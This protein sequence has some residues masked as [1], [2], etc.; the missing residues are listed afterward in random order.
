LIAQ[1]LERDPDWTKLPSTTPAPVRRLLERCLKKD[2][3][4]RLH[5]I[6]DARFTIEDALASPVFPLD[7]AQGRKDP[8]LHVTADPG[9]HPDQAG[10]HAAAVTRALQPT[11]AVWRHPLPVGLAIATLALA[12]ALLWTLNRTP[13]ADATEPTHVSLTLPVTQELTVWGHT[14]SPD[15][16]HIV[17]SAVTDE[18]P[19]GPEGN[20]SRLFHRNLADGASRPLPGTEGAGVPF[21]SPDGEWVAFASLSDL[22][23]KR[24]ALGGGG[25]T[26]VADLSGSNLEYPGAWTS[27]DHILFGDRVGPLRRVPSAGGPSEVVVPRTALEAGEQGMTWP[28]PLP[29]GSGTMFNPRY[30]F[31]VVA[32]YVDGGRRTLL[33]DAFQAQFSPTGHLL[34]WRAADSKQVDVWAVG[35]DATRAELTGTPVSVLSVPGTSQLFCQVS[36]SGTLVYRA[37]DPE[38]H[39]G[40]FKWEALDGRPTPPQLT[41]P[42]PNVSRISGPRISPDGR[43]V[44]Y[45]E[46]AGPDDLRLIVADLT[47]G[48]R[49]ILAAGQNF[50]AI[51][52]PDSR[53]VV[54]QVP[55]GE[56]GGAGI[57]WKPADGSTAPERL[58]SSKVWQQPQ[59]VTRDGRFLIYQEGGA[60]GT[61]D[62]A[63][64][65]NYDLWLLPLSPRGEPRPLLQSKANE[66]L[67]SL[68]PDGRWLAYV[69]DETGRE[70]IWVR[71]FPPEGSAA[72]QV[73]Q[74]GGTEPVWA[75]NGAT[76]YY[77]D[78]AGM[79]LYAVP[80]THGSVPQFGAPTVRNGRWLGLMPFGRL[81]DITPD[82][83][84]LLFL[85]EPTHSRELRVVFNFDQVIR[86][87]MA[88]ALK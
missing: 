20:V 29:G 30:D 64:A 63:G 15:G 37:G 87:K 13:A 34:F 32:V 11:R 55:P 53:R 9:R 62:A 65:D 14:V 59:F 6:A 3:R 74:S 1:I 8:G 82:G 51:W 71:V 86:R 33:R 50:W 42:P 66:K 70:E 81:Y 56:P 60:I 61:R 43:F 57:L 52:M 7:S 69:S 38:Y 67:P 75:P 26:A 39:G 83:S 19:P 45:H 35:F 44:L 17:Y 18:G 76:L 41:D 21:F 49:R 79:R 27:T 12:A 72:I 48:T 23:L 78:A 84:A 40:R 77:R 46:V 5:H 31:G 58:T 2:P 88:A 22:K 80:V 24:I 4:Q 25:P 47:T 36:R 28:V 54:Y 10:A 73:S 16:R 85:A 68:S